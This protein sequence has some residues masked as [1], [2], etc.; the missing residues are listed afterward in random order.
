MKLMFARTK[1]IVWRSILLLPASILL[2]ITVWI[3]KI[4]MSGVKFVS[5][6]S[7]A[8]WKRLDAHLREAPN[9]LTHLAWIVLYL[10]FIFLS[11]A[12]CI[13]ILYP[14]WFLFGVLSYISSELNV[15]LLRYVQ[16]RKPLASEKGIVDEAMISLKQKL[17]ES[18]ASDKDIL[19]LFGPEKKEL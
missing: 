11:M 15:S 14:L 6:K 1:G 4:V 5:M 8:E 10:P 2:L 3:S 19:D 13:L 17:K 18:G 16:F 12:C 7:G 9:L